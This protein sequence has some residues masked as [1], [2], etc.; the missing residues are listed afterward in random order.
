[1]VSRGGLVLDKRIA[2]AHRQCSVKILLV[3]AGMSWP[4]SV[5]ILIASSRKI[6]VIEQSELIACGGGLSADA[7][8]E[9]C[10]ECRKQRL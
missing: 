7:E 5:E 2:K 1:M 3:L 4:R 10:S 8:H 6:V 9:Q